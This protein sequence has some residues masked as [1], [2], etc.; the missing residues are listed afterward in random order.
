MA[1]LNR[2]AVSIAILTISLVPTAVLAATDDGDT[3]RRQ[4][5]VEHYVEAAQ[6]APST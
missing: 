2:L 5:F 6:R 4:L 1:M 3:L